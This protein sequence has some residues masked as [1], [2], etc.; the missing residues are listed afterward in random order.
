[1]ADK[2]IAYVATEQLPALPPPPATTGPMGWLKEKQM[3][4]CWG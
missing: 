2:T 4:R 3:E 1:M